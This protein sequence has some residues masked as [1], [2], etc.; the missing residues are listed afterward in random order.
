MKKT[1][2]TILMAIVIGFTFGY[3]FL[4]KFNTDTLMEVSSIKSQCYAFQVGVYKNKE[5]AYRAASTYK[6]IVILDNDLYRVY[7]ALLKDENLLNSLKEYYD[8]NGI[9]YYL[10]AINISNKTN[11]IVDNYE[12][13]LKKTS[14]DNYGLIL[15]NMLKEVDANEL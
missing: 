5:N 13:I 12:I 9:S 10:K 15:E 11:S 1:L 7:I 6:G 14:L 2:F 8:K 3:L 4:R